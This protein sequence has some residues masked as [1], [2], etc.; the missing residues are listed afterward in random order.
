MEKL[1]VGKI[2]GTHGLK[3]EVKIK[4]NSSFSSERFKPGNNITIKK[5]DKSINLECL[6]H[7]VHKGMD[8]VVF[9]GH[10]DINLIEKYRDYEVYADYDKNLLDDDEYF[11]GE[12]IGCT[13][14]TND[15]RVLGVVE[16]LM[17]APRYEILV[18]KREGKKNLLIPYIEAF[19]LEDNI[20]NKEIIVSLIEGMED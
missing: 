20:D 5:N 8:L 6:R 16:S 17:E 11:Y 7:R 13:V 18:V 12:I 9:K 1:L 4:S 19:V 10:E 14:K 2:V 3:G 15:N